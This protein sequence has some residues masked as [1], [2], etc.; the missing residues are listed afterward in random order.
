MFLD[1]EESFT[2]LQ[3]A[4]TYGY[5]E[6]RHWKEIQIV[7]E[8]DYRFRHGDGYDLCSIHDNFGFDVVIIQVL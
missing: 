1:R 3:Y 6:E 2:K 7:L 5:F 4:K 8:D